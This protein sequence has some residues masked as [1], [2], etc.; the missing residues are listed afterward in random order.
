MCVPDRRATA[1]LT[2]PA[3]RGQICMSCMSTSV[4]DR[5][6]ALG[7]NSHASASTT[8]ARGHFLSFSLFFPSLTIC[9]S[10]CTLSSGSG[11]ATSW[12][13]SPTPPTASP[14]W[15]CACSCAHD[16]WQL[17]PL[18]CA[19]H[20][21]GERVWCVR[22]PA[23]ALPHLAHVSAAPN[24]S[25]K[26]GLPPTCAC[27][28]RTQRLSPRV[29]PWQVGPDRQLQLLHADLGGVDPAAARHEHSGGGRRHDPHAI[30]APPQPGEAARLAPRWV[31]SLVWCC[32]CCKMGA[33]RRCSAR[34]GGKTD[35]P[36]LLP[37]L[38]PRLLLLP[39]RSTTCGGILQAGFDNRHG[40]AAAL[41]PRRA[42]C[43]HGLAGG[44]CQ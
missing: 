18:Y 1:A 14:T 22:L 29:C 6:T 32:C 4:A 17:Q 26:L 16:W 44:G 39:P 5:Q 13:S 42:L 2:A 38:L 37:L 34:Q 23:G 15:S 20:C 10:G 12:A 21:C 41:L 24:V 3:S 43:R 33:R 36:P 35:C 8:H 7:H 31:P 28:S 19:A 9:R 25:L 40:P 11:P 30:S 27:L